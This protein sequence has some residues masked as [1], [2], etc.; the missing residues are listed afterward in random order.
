MVGMLSFI[1][2]NMLGS[3]GVEIVVVVVVEGILCLYV[4]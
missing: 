4:L 3:V 2:S 1:G